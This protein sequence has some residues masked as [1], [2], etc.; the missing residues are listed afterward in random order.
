MRLHSIIR[1]QAPAEFA[2]ALS[3]GEEPDPAYLQLPEQ[4]SGE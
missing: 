1:H 4:Q 3:S 2:Q